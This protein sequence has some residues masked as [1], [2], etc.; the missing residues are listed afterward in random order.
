MQY[1]LTQVADPKRFQR[2]VNALLTARFGE[3]F[4]HTPLQGK[5]GASDGETAVDNPFME[6]ICEE[7]VSSPS[8]N[9]LIKAPRPGRYLFQAK[10]HSTGEHRLSDLRSD[11]V[12]EFKEALIND[13]LK[14]SDRHD[15]N[16]FF[17][18]TNISAS[19][20]ALC[21]IDDI[22]SELLKKNRHLHADVWWGERI[23][24]LLDW[25]PTL[26]QA[27]PELFPGGVPPLLG[28]A[29]TA[30]AEGL[31]RTLKL[32][33]T[34]QHIRD[35]QI[36]F[37]QIELE[38]RLIDLFV[39]LDF[40]FVSDPDEFIRLQHSS[41]LPQSST[42]LLL[43][44]DVS[45]RLHSGSG[46]VLQLL[47]N[48]DIGISKILL[49]GGPGQ[50]KSTITQMAAQIYREKFLEVRDSDERDPTWHQFCQLRIPIR[51]ELR[52]FAH[53]LSTN[54]DGTL[55]QYIAITISQDSGGAA[56]LPED[57]HRMLNH[58]SAIFL[59]DGLDEVGNDDL[60]DQVLEVALSAIH[61]IEN[62]LNTN[63]RVVLTTRPPA[64]QGH[65]NK[66]DGFIR[67]VVA[68]MD[69]RKIND[70]L[71]RWLQAQIP[72]IEERERIKLSFN[73]RRNDSHVEAL[74]R[75]P[76]Q[77][78]VLLQFI[79]LKGDAFPDRRAE[80]YR[81]YFQIVIDRDVEKS[82][83]LSTHRDLIEGL[84]SYLGFLLHGSAEVENGRRA[85]SRNHIVE[86]A[87]H[88]LH[89][90]GHPPQLAGEYFAL[91]EERFGLIVALSGEG[92]E[93]TYGFEVQP[94][95]E[96]FA[97]A[98]ISN[99][100]ENGRA[101][102]VFETLL[103]KEYWREVALFLAGLR[104]PNEK[105]DLVLRAKKADAESSHSEKQ[106]GRS[107][108]LQLLREGVLN[109]P[110]NVQM[111]AMDYALEFLDIANLRQH[112][113]PRELI[114]IMRVVIKQNN[115]DSV[116]SKVIQA[117]E[118]VCQTNDHSLLTLILR[119]AGTVLDKE[120]YTKVVLGYLGQE[121]ETRGL[122]RVTAPFNVSRVIEE[123][124][125]NHIYWEGIPSHVLARRLWL[126]ATLAR[127]VP[128]I[129][130]PV[131]AHSSL[132]VQFAIGL[133]N[134]ALHGEDVI[135][136]SSDSVPAIWKL[137]QNLQAIRILLSN[138][139]EKESCVDAWLST[140]SS[141]RLLW[142]DG[143]SEPLPNSYKRCLKDLIKTSDSVVTS[144][145]GKASTEIRKSVQVYWKTIFKYLEEPGIVA[146]IAARCATEMYRFAT[147]GQSE[148]L[149]EV[150]RDSVV[151]VLNEF[152]KIP[153]IEN[154][155]RTYFR[156][157]MPL[158]VRVERGSN[159]R[160]LHEI[161]IDLVLKRSELNE[162]E[163]WGWL[164]EL[165][166]APAIIGKLVDGCR[167]ELE[168]LLRFIGC[169]T[170]AS[171]HWYFLDQR[172][173]VQDTQRILKVCRRTEERD[174]LQGASIVLMNATF[175]RL[176]ETEL[177]LKILAASQGSP[178]GSRIFNSHEGGIMGEQDPSLKEFALSV[179][180]GVLRQPDDYPF[181]VANLAAVFLSE[182]EA[183][184]NL[185]LFEQCP[186]LQK[187]TN[188]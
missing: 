99:R 36:K 1:N 60:R 57:V 175:G 51:L 2:L 73:N 88:W 25:A 38:K 106:N 142:T 43:S 157:G 49:E 5:D 90:E 131:G 113:N 83:E 34:Q 62:A 71:K 122:V 20:A 12:R 32:A 89:D 86:L 135:A 44:D 27:F 164:R 15:V 187:S 47:L 107:M 77:L 31:S 30:S 102:E 183:Q 136:I 162:E 133:P 55:E 26:W 80:L 70:Y 104:R 23:T 111:E 103:Y 7:D 178:L 139:E 173:K 144:L 163:L 21:K 100:L 184:R 146:W 54:P 101:H 48:D 186:D 148:V 105:A 8:T 4:R 76:M 98:Y 119:L 127:S 53:W 118:S 17:L 165:P 172:I 64:V 171:G 132:I 145:I 117:V 170:I 161:L 96:Y 65:W 168:S 158:A 81:D 78:S 97:A 94:I 151:N 18:V 35:S 72:A 128:K 141:V 110:R 24:S 124:G 185:P 75:N 61:R 152:Y 84:H 150:S 91:G 93:T 121:P 180:R 112:R 108:V 129:A 179:A 140:G 66:L 41:N 37:R 58:S 177:I 92:D 6:Y 149:R 45:F 3:D 40:D 176:A 126:G 116:Q 42:K 134:I 130:Y 188:H 46:T 125:S 156:F 109:Q 95:Q 59:F 82:P 155:R 181:E 69:R 182:V 10:Y 160:P 39:D 56:V 68:P 50:G 115:S 167:N 174:V 166:L 120:D 63:L 9:P 79:Y 87:G 147:V 85:L 123:L 67:V 11:V 29:A 74:A 14:R 16:Y 137:Y 159:L 19:K 13:V 114:A 154:P 52:D 153:E 138:N 33:I 22:C 28:T 143:Q 169:R